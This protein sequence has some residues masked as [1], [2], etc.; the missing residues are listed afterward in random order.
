MYYICYK[1][2][3]RITAATLKSNTMPKEC[4]ITATTN[5]VGLRNLGTA[6][7]ISC[8]LMECAKTAI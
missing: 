5:S 6:H 3:K 2:R 1:E 8:M 4:A 7:I